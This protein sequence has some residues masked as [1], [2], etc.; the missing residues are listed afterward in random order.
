MSDSKSARRRKNEKL[1]QMRIEPIWTWRTMP[2]IVLLFLT[3]K[4]LA[5][6]LVLL[7]TVVSEDGSNGVD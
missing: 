5:C 3:R 4:T 2:T 7:V 1:Y 6:S